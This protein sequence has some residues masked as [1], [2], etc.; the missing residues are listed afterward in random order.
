MLN[1]IE[2]TTVPVIIAIVYGALALYKYIF[3]GKETLI[4]IIPIIAAV[5]GVILGIVAFY[6]VP[7]AI[8][9]NDILT[10]ILIGGASGLAAT[11]T[12]QIFK[13]L[14]KKT[15]E[16]VKPEENI[17]SDEKTEDDKKDMPE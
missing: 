15:D 17:K 7:E 13:Q 12:H 8:P 6:V 5:L 11:G 3:E 9:A 2:V 14:T 4:K 16:N 1:L 10:A